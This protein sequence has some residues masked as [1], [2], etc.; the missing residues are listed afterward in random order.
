MQLDQYDWHT[1]VRWCPLYHHLS[2]DLLEIGHLE[3]RGD[4]YTAA[5]GA[6]HRAGACVDGVST[7]RRLVL[8]WGKPQV[9]RHVDAPNHEHPVFPLNLANRV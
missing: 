2:V 8:V 9:I 1:C 3:R 7:S 5:D 6:G 4:R